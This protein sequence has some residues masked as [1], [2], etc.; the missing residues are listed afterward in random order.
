MSI[1]SSSEINYEDEVIPGVAA[2]SWYYVN[3]EDH[4]EWELDEN[5]ENA[6]YLGEAKRVNA[7][8]PSELLYQACLFVET[9]NISEMSERFDRTIENGDISPLV[10][11]HKIKKIAQD[12]FSLVGSSKNCKRRIIEF[13]HSVIRCS[14]NMDDIAS[15]DE[16]YKDLA[17]RYKK[18]LQL[19]SELIKESEPTAIKLDTRI[20]ALSE[21]YNRC[22]VW[23][24]HNGVKQA[25]PQ[26][27]EIFILPIPAFW[28]RD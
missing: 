24:D 25:L 13:R 17:I 10:K 11:I 23:L 9:K 1:N 2:G 14:N 21:L 19:T 26:L 20:D 15:S 16:Q 8:I 6:L 27:N 3:D 4:D 18:D 7:L 12:A 28:E 5:L 22:K